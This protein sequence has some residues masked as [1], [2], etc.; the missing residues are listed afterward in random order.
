MLETTATRP[1][2]ASE[3]SSLAR[4]GLIAF[5][6]SVVNGLAAFL[7]IV[8]ITNVLDDKTSSGLVFTAIALFNIVFAV[9]AL[10]ADVGLVR[11][12]AQNRSSAVALLKTAAIP[13]LMSS[14]LMAAAIAV[15]RHP[16]AN[17]L[18]AN[19]SDTLAQILLG[20]TPFV[21][22]ATLATVILAGTRGLGTMTPTALA[23]RI[24]KPISQLALVVFVSLLGAGPAGI[25]LAWSVSFAV[26]FALAVWWFWHL[27]SGRESD[28]AVTREE[29]W[30]FTAPQAATNVL[31]V[32]LRWADVLLV[33]AL[34]GEGPAAIYTAVSRLLIAGNFV[35]GAIVQAISPL[36]SKALGDNNRRGADDLLKTGTAW[37]VAAVWPGYLILA[38]VGGPLL[39][40]LFGDGY[41]TGATALTVLSFA[42]MV[43][44]GSGPI[45]AVLLM[46]GGS[47]L[48]LI[49]NLAAVTVMLTVDALLIPELGVR[50][51]A[52]GWGAG[53]MITNVVPLI[54][55]HRRLGIS[56]FGRAH[57]VASAVGLACVGGPAALLRLTGAATLLSVLG[58]AVVG[59][60]LHL[61]LLSRFSTILKL[62]QLVSAVKSRG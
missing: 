18:S 27:T 16:I 47:R 53:L 34:A 6:G 52:I 51:A 37:L 19:D 59:Y 57:L 23:D 48:S 2:D 50:G 3:Q 10:G 1:E 4:S 31:Y 35:N 40:T 60:A 41:S 11:F 43:A 33:A 9:A 45:E 42:M 30:D 61:A 49:N 8:A 62:D 58:V 29:Y 17:I 36:V 13:A 14:C 55:V 20:M 54:Q 44:S 32:L 12:T 22:L 39:V 21:P 28:L 26:S 25:G 56:P 15:A 46:D 7:V 5:A 24:G 38:L